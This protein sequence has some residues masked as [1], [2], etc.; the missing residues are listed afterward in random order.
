MKDFL[1]ETSKENW[2]EMA[3]LGIAGV[4]QNNKNLN[5]ANRPDWPIIDGDLLSKTLNIK[6]FKLYNDFEIASYSVLK[7]HKLKVTQINNATG[8][9]NSPMVVCGVGTGLG[10]SFIGP[11]RWSDNRY[12]FFVFPTEA[13]HA[14]F[15]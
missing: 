13:G 2:P 3:H 14:G 5:M 1:K 7:L 10:V 8:F 12:K 11:V 4:I 9:E 15:P 6:F